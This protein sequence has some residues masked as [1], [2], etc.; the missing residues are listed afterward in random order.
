MPEAVVV[1]WLRRW[2]CT[3]KTDGLPTERK[4]TDGH[5]PYT[6]QQLPPAGRGRPGRIDPFGE[7]DS[8]REDEHMPTRDHALMATS[9]ASARPHSGRG[10]APEPATNGTAAWVRATYPPAGGTLPEEDEDGAVWIRS[11]N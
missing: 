2:R 11:Y 5:W 6:R 9:H 7:P 1:P 8:Q 10:T 4:V 3:W